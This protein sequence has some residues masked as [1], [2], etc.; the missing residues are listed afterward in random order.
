MPPSY[1]QLRPGQGR[2]DLLSC[3]FKGK[4]LERRSGMS[5]GLAEE[6]E[7]SESWT[8][9][10]MLTANLGDERLKRRVA[11]ILSRLAD[12]PEGSVPAAFQ[13]WAETLAAYRFFDNERV[14]PEK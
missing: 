12:R 3:F 6:I 5:S 9:Q 2:P 13:S 11:K 8:A 1:T 14:T 7:D 4:H 10:E